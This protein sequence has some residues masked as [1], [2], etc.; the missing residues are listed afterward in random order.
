MYSKD[1][2]SV[3]LKVG[4]GSA[5][6]SI[7]C[8]I[9]CVAIY[10]WYLVH[11]GPSLS[12]SRWRLRAIQGRSKLL[13]LVQRPK[14]RRLEDKKQPRP[15]TFIQDADSGHVSPTRFPQR[16]GWKCS[17]SKFH[18]AAFRTILFVSNLY[19]VIY[20]E[21]LVDS[22]LPYPSH[23]ASSS[24]HSAPENWCWLGLGIA[25]LT[26]TPKQMFWTTEQMK[27]HC[28]FAALQ[29][30]KPFEKLPPR[31]IRWITAHWHQAQESPSMETKKGSHVTA[32]TGLFSLFP[33]L[34]SSNI[35]KQAAYKALGH[36][37]IRPKNWSIAHNIEFQT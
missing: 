25:C 30:P 10:H 32:A 12:S 6:R 19:K 13:D 16:C 33:S 27:P 31:L 20:R 29:S 36:P 24:L 1:S 4:D 7:F 28:N 3:G 17:N 11:I 37:R 22:T 5:R 2:C 18:R 14:K 21:R 9:L 35:W 15:H 8:F 23:P 34:F 26:F